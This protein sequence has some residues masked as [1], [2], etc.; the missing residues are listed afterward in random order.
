M[1]FLRLNIRRK[2]YYTVPIYIS[3]NWQLE[4]VFIFMTVTTYCSVVTAVVA[5][6]TF[7]MLLG[8]QQNTLNINIYS[9]NIS[10]DACIDFEVAAK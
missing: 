9:T 5:D 7:S 8:T 3:D 6:V 1:H 2:V 4:R 10:K